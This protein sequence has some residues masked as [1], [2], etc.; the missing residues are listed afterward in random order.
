[1]SGTISIAP[2]RKSITVEAAPARAFEIFTLGI[3]RWWPRTHS[4]GSEP[5]KTSVIEPFVGGRWYA[6][7]ESGAEAVVGHVR[8][9]Q[10]GERFVVS[11]EINA[12]WAPEARAQFASEVE[13]RFVA[14]GRGRTRVEVEHR[15]FERMEQDGEKMRNAVDGGWPGLLE[16]YATQLARESES[17]EAIE[18]AGVKLPL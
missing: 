9:W 8:A 13:V 18:I 1:M 2:V 16:L 12:S 4:V 5:I 6:V 7:G 11:W 15:D 3:D 14:Q 10:P 17:P